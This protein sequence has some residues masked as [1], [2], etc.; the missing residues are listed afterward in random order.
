ML[1]L[2]ITS[3]PAA[4]VP[5]ASG[6]DPL[7]TD[8]GFLGGAVTSPPDEQR[9][10]ASWTQFAGMGLLTGAKYT[11]AGVETGLDWITGG[12]FQASS[13]SASNTGNRF[14]D[15]NKDT[16]SDFGNLVAGGS[17]GRRKLGASP[18]PAAAA[19]PAEKGGWMPFAQQ[20][21]ATGAG[22]A[23]QGADTAFRFFTDPDFDFQKEGEA[24]QASGAATGDAFG[25]L[26]EGMAGAA[27]AT[28]PEEKRG[29]GALLDGALLMTGH[30]DLLGMELAEQ[31]HPMLGLAAMEMGEHREEQRREDEYRRDDRY[32]YGEYGRGE[33]GRHGGGR[34]LQAAEGA[35]AAEAVSPPAAAAA[36][37]EKG[38][39]MPFAQ[40][41]AATGAGF[42]SQGADTAFRFFTDP[43]FDF[44]KEG[45]AY[46][47]SG[48]ATGDA[49]GTLSE[50]MAGAAAAT[51]PEEKRFR[52]LLDGALLA[53]GHD[54]LAGVALASQG[55]PVLGLAAIEHG[56]RREEQRREEERYGRYEE[57][58]RHHHMLM[59]R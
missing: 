25:T 3:G 22:F 33:H 38:G 28:P 48:A 15:L 30:D 39:W 44:Q 59:G 51:P 37:A 1:A 19:A 10:P 27:A 45:E 47:A 17:M 56:E 41:G 23:S 5:T 13:D 49:F 46:Q 24:Y 35:E 21:A 11:A 50:G 16:S 43:D 14:S 6:G 40:Q 12:A 26:S 9:G 7:T 52:P 54:K 58:G 34:W 4:P 20:G 57:P 31:G 29:G 32:E 55:H 2:A 53:T 36:P 18:P 42:A 8:A